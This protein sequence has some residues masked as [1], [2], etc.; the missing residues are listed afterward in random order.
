MVRPLFV[1]EVRQNGRVVAS[2]PPEVINPAIASPATIAKTMVMLRGVVEHGTA[3]NIK[4]PV[5]PIAGKTGTARVAL[6]NRG[7][8]EGS[9]VRYKG[10][11]V[12]FFPADDPKY[13]CIVVINNPSKGKYYGGSIAAPVFREIS[14]RLYAKQQEIRTP[15][16]PDTANVHTPFAKAGLQN[17]LQTVF[18]ALGIPASGVSVPDSWVRTRPDDYRVNLFHTEV[19]KGVMPDVT[20]MGLKDA[21][22]VLEQQGLRVIVNGKGSVVKQSLAPGTLISKGLPVVID[23]ETQKREEA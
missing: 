23:L 7:Y 3:T 8:G 22:F 15:L 17:D 14:D 20:G 18:A 12:G 9:A 4:S 16:A 10:T 2:F 5:Y 1:K 11:F 21:L 19:V 6:N 13:S